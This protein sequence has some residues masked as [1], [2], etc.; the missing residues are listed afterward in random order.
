MATPHVIKATSGWE[1]CSMAH[2]CH[3]HATQTLFP[4][5]SFRDATSIDAYSP[6]VLAGTYGLKTLYDIGLT[7]PTALGQLG[8]R[9]YDRLGG[10]RAEEAAAEGAGTKE[11]AGAQPDQA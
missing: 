10:F 2:F 4:L 6:P 1:R 7:P 3:V 8:Y 11:E 5:E 9:H